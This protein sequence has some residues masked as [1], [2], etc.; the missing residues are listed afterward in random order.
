VRNILH[1]QIEQ[2]ADLE[3]EEKL[4]RRWRALVGEEMKYRSPPQRSAVRA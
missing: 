3:G 1:E 4:E 2:Q